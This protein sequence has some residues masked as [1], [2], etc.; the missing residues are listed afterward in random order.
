[1]SG[2][3]TYEKPRIWRYQPIKQ[4][5][6]PS[7]SSGGRNN[8]GRIVTFHRGGGHKKRFRVIDFRRR[9]I[10][11]PAT[12]IRLERDTVRG[13]PLV[14][15]AYAN[16]VL[17]YILGV[18]DLKYSAIISSGPY[19]QISPGCAT[20]FKRIPIG[21][22]VCNIENKIGMGGTFIHSAGTKA[23]ILRKTKKFAILKLP[24]GELRAFNQKAYATIGA[25]EQA[26]PF[27]H[28]MRKAGA[29]RWLGNRPIVRGVA[30]NPIDHPHGG[31]EG[32]T[33]GGRPSCSPWGILTK[34]LKTR[35]PRKSFVHIIRTRHKKYV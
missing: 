1:M 30:Q 17:S 16:G 11:V 25:L 20:T 28:A 33:S 3:S 2:L 23:Q 19:A 13:T 21:Q 9:F 8:Q 5:T 6:I 35:S 4:L 24:S 14:L 7:T 22:V 15:L 31:G 26:S 12:V 10:G 32:K 27:F 18:K 34:G 29:N